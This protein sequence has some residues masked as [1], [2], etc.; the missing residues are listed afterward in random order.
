[1]LIA[2]WSVKGGSG[3]TVLAAAHAI[4][5]ATVVPTLV[6]DLDGDLPD[7]LGVPAPAAGVAEWLS[8][9]DAVPS[10]AL[11]RLTV[12]VGPNL[13]LLGR[14][15]GPLAASPTAAGLDRAGV[16]AGLLSVAPYSVVVD[17]GTRPGPVARAVVASAR[18]SVLVTRA[19]YLALRRQAGGDLAPTEVAVVREGARSLSLDDVARSV[20]A[21]IRTTVPHDPAIARAVDAGLLASRLPRALAR[22]VDRS[23]GQPLVR[24]P[25]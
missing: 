23:L 9:G 11:D 24:T 18:R 22:P 14:G 20:G 13:R 21:P 15:G 4:R 12:E 2:Y 17:C 19:C 3:T 7:V 6:V 1:M 16:L 25:A 10:D 8:A 5:A